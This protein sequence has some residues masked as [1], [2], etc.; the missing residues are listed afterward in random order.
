MFNLDDVDHDITVWGIDQPPIRY[1]TYMSISN[2]TNS[3]HSIGI[4]IDIITNRKNFNYSSRF[5]STLRY[6]L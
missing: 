3:L 5:M 2:C 6:K 1:E 4:S